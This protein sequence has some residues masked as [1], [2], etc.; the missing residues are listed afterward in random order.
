[1]SSWAPTTVILFATALIAAGCNEV[2]YTPG[3]PT[4][5]SEPTLPSPDEPQ[6][7]GSGDTGARGRGSCPGPVPLSDP[8]W[9]EPPLPRTACTSADLTYLTNVSGP[10]VSYPDAEASLR[11]R[12]PDCA[13]CIFSHDLDKTWGP[14]VLVGP[15]AKALGFINMGSCFARAPGGSMTCGRT[16]EQLMLCVDAVC[17]PT[18]CAD[19]NA[20]QKCANAT[21]LNPNE[22]GHYDVNTACGGPSSYATLSNACRHGFDVIR[23][24]CG[25]APSP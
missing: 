9:K 8:A 10:N 7:A 22:C 4:T 11:S 25:G 12:A 24:M 16:M 19:E 1:M 13:D 18:A 21:A 5:G 15:A 2:T 3:Q 6:D 23:T 14:V 17:P 20:R